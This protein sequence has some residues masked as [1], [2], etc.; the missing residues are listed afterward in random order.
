MGQWLQEREVMTSLIKQHL[1]RVRMKNQADKGRS[2]RAFSVGDLVFLKLQPYVQSS[3]APHANQKLAFKFFGPFPVL[4]KVRA[5]AYQLALPAE[6]KIHPV[7]HVSQLKK[8]IESN[9]QVPSTLPQEL[10]A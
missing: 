4:K 10:S 1:Q 3:L 2:E 6:S 8:A 9:I 5:E 7:F